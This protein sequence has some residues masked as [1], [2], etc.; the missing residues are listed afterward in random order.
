MPSKTLFHNI[1]KLICVSKS[2]ELKKA[3]K[4][5]RELAL[6]DNA[7]MLVEDDLISG[8]GSMH[9][10]PTGIPDPVDC[11]GRM[12]LPGFVDAH[13]HVLYC[14]NRAEEFAMRASGKTYVEIAKAGGG[15]QNSLK[16]VRDASEE[17]LIQET[18]PRINEMLS[19]GT[20]T[21]E[22]KRKLQFRFIPLF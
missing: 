9:A 20:T 17:Q 15:I 6:I 4:A 10:A 22:I 18:L 8:I 1:S 12:M 5:M 2:G 21:L 11:T 14:G 16:A 7:F 3:G 19:H 13:T